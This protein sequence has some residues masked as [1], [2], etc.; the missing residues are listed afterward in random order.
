L[1]RLYDEARRTPT[2]ADDQAVMAISKARD[3]A[4]KIDGEVAQIRA[5]IRDSAQRRNEL[6]GARDRARR[7]GY[8]NPMGNFGGQSDISEVIGNILRGVVVGGALDHVLRDNY[9]SPVP[10][11]DPDFGGRQSG[12]SW[13]SPWSGPRQ[14][15]SDSSG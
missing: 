6:E 7:A 8:D 11:A 1:R 13:S 10:R 3:A 2:P 14:D 15:S 5:Q 4:Q 9:R 12:P